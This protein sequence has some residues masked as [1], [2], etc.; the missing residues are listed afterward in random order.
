M[1]VLAG[2]VIL[3]ILLYP[4]IARTR[5]LTVVVMI[6]AMGYLGAFE[7]TREAARRPYIVNEVMYSNGILKEQVERINQEGFLKNAKWAQNKEVTQANQLEAGRELF[8]HQCFA[9]HTVGG[10]NNDIV[11]RTRNMSYGAMQKYLAT[12]HQKR[13][14]MPPFAGNES[15]L[16][17][18]AAYLTAGLHKKPL[19]E[20]VADIGDHGKRLFDDNCAACHGGDVL[21]PKMAG[22]SKEKIRASLDKLASLNPAMPDY[23]APV[24]DKDAVADYLYGLNNPDPGA[25]VKEQGATL[26]EDNCAPCHGLDVLRPKVSGWSRAKIR[27]ALDNLSALNPGMPDYTGSAAEKDS[28]AEYMLKQAG[29]VK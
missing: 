9:C 25:P 13:Y 5:V 26:F 6:A 19:T 12:I 1:A 15:E 16:K 18:L 11:I 8:L 17:A 14:F 2:V 20:E 7:W 24:A 3:L 22:W 28:L 29:G 10:F 27:T 23:S 4:K 21:K